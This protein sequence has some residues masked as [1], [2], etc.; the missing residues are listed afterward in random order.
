MNRIIMIIITI[1]LLISACSS[2]TTSSMDI[3][4]AIAQTQAAQVPPSNV[5]I[6]KTSNSNTPKEL[7]SPTITKKPTEKLSPTNTKKPIIKSTATIG[8][9]TTRGK[10]QNYIAVQDSGGVTIEVARIL[11]ADKTA[12]P[13]PICPDAVVVGLPDKFVDKITAVEF[14][15]RITNNTNKIVNL[16]AGAGTVSVNGEQIDLA[17]Y[18]NVLCTFGDDI[19]GEFLPGTVAIGGIWAGVKRTSWDQV[20]NILISISSPFGM[21]YEDLGPDYYF[22]IDASGW[23]FEPIPDE[24]KWMWWRWWRGRWM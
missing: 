6:L 1:A 14:I 8:F 21:L 15:F 16:F 12:I 22:E 3:E 17:H 9:D 23:T 5:E 19:G 24:L 13:Q 20:S 10:A 4:T 2:P 18:R 7:L 11:I